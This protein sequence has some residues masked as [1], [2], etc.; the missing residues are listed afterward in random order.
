[1]ISFILTFFLSFQNDCS[2]PLCASF[3]KLAPWG[4]S[5]E[6]LEAAL[7]NGAVNELAFWRN[8][9]HNQLVA[10]GGQGGVLPAATPTQAM[11]YEEQIVAAA[12]GN[13]D[14]QRRSKSSGK[15]MMVGAGGKK[16]GKKNRRR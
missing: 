4:Y 8:I 7:K 1:M 9:D 5:D 6:A 12:G 3:P 10:P 16:G 13:K 15:G 11:S 14:N 2:F